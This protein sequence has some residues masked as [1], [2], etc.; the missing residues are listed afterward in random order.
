MFKDVD[1]GRTE[2]LTQ[3]I[4]LLTEPSALPVLPVGATICNCA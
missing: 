1:L 2:R 4:R 3:H